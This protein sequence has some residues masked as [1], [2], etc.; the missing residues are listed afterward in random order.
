MRPH[1]G[2]LRV[3]GNTRKAPEPRR[4]QKEIS[5]SR[6]PIFAG[7]RRTMREQAEWR[8]GKLT[9]RRRRRSRFSPARAGGHPMAELSPEMEARARWAVRMGHRP[10]LDELRALLDALDAERRR[11]AEFAF[12]LLDALDAERQQSKRWEQAHEA[13]RIALGEALDQRDAER[14]RV[15]ELDQF[16]GGVQHAFWS[17]QQGKRNAAS[18]MQLIDD[19]LAAIARAALEEKP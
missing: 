5:A 6:A 4:K 19:L 8:V 13:L 16:L 12:A 18:A 7:P 2:R 11:V 14:R 9:Q 3:C 17:Y 15:K 10:S 1:M